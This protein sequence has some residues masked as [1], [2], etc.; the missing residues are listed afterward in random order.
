M[1]GSKGSVGGFAI[2][3]LLAFAL[4]LASSGGG[5]RAAAAVRVRASASAGWAN[6]TASPM[7]DTLA[8]AMMAYDSTANRFLLFGGW[9]GD[10]VNQTWLFDPANRTW[11]QIMTTVAPSSRGDAQLVYD[12]Q[13]GVFL[14]FGGWHEDANGSYVR[15]ADTWTF[16]LGNRTWQE[17]HP[18]SAPAPRSDAAIA[19]D[20]AHGQLFLFGGF[21]GTTYLGDAWSYAYANDTWSP[22]PSAV[23][24]SARADGRM[25]Y[26]EIDGRFFLY[27]GN[28]Y[29]D[30]NLNFHHLADTWEYSWASNR[31]AQVMTQGSPGPR[32]YAVLAYDSHI[33]GLL[34]FG[35]YGDRTILGDTWS[36]DI[37]TRSWHAVAGTLA[38]PP[39]FAG[40][41][42]YDPRE[43]AFVV[44]GGLGNGGLRSDTW[45]LPQFVLGMPGPASPVHDGVILLFLI[46]FGSLVAANALGLPGHLRRRRDARR[47]AGRDV[48][49]GGVGPGR[50]R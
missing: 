15:L 50:P 36:Y 6:V 41:G 1:I 47:R 17:L 39:R 9:D 10:G 18:R 7:P 16:A 8:G 26:D 28:D 25:V 4:V 43:D 32:D 42:G 45:I 35:G 19:F 48:E 40:V 13:D 21:N 14:L 2:L 44:F 24:P 3:A 38:P 46:G 49:S 37:A 11:S 33:A 12:P 29:S 23:M 31:W 20:S 34:L 22:R 30:A 5:T 27:G